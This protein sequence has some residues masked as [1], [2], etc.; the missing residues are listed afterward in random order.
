[1]CCNPCNPWDL[2]PSA[3]LLEVCFFF[4]SRHVWASK[5]CLRVWF[6]LKVVA[7]HRRKLLPGRSCICLVSYRSASA[8][9]GRLGP[10]KTNQHYNKKQQTIIHTGHLSCTHWSVYVVG[11]HL[12]TVTSCCSPWYNYSSGWN[13]IVFSLKRDLS[14][15]CKIHLN[16]CFCAC[17]KKNVEETPSETALCD[18]QLFDSPCPAT[19]LLKFTLLLPEWAYIHFGVSVR[20]A[21]AVATYLLSNLFWMSNTTNWLQFDRMRSF[22]I[23]ASTRD[24]LV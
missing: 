16:A 14:C 20:E 7:K 5:V 9:P 1:M 11:M 23:Y 18:L 19:F 24:I 13:Q 2:G 3:R 22:L 12:K 4:K 15:S 17:I 10:T 8:M 21:Q 6:D